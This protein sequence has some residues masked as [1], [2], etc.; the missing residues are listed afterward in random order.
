MV[1]ALG[2]VTLREN[3]LKALSDG[4]DVFGVLLTGYGK[5]SYACRPK[6]RV[7]NIIV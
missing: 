3:L 2:Y 1:Q 6:P 5:L 4:Y 7:P